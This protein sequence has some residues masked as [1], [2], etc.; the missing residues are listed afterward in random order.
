MNARLNCLAALMPV[1]FIMSTTIATAAD[2]Y[3]ADPDHMSIVFSAS[4]CGFSYVYGL[5]RKAQGG[6]ILDKA[7]PANCRFR[8]AIDAASL[9]T[10]QAMRDTHLKGDEFFHVEK[11]PAIQFES[12]ACTVTNTSEG[13]VYQVTGNMT[14]HGVTR[15]ITIPLRQLG[16]GK[17]PFND[18]RAG[19]VTSFQLKRSDFKM[20]NRLDMVGDPVTINIS[21]EGILQD[22]SGNPARPQ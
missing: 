11:Y 4:H 20:D 17:S 7:N 2:K 15:Q 22:A 8:F 21:F 18:Y 16:E 1:V 14:L 10:N 5:F 9:D 6:F 3:T 13:V 12:T 19:F